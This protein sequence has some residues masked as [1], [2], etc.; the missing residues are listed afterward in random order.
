MKK[1]F[2]LIELMIVIGIIGVLAGVILSQF[3]G[4]TESSRLAVCQSNMRNLA[5]ACQSAAMSSGFYPRA[6]T[7]EYVTM[8][9]DGD[10]IRGLYSGWIGRPDDHDHRGQYS[11]HV[12][13]H[14]IGCYTTDEDAARQ[15]IS[16]GTIF[17]SMSF[18]RK[19][20]VCPGH[21]RSER[22]KS[23]RLNPQF[24]YAMNCYFGYDS[25]DGSEATAS[26]GY[27]GVAYGMSRAD[28]RLLF[29]E[30]PFTSVQDA[31]FSTSDSAELDC[32]LHYD[33]GESG[34][35]E[36]I[37]FNHVSGKLTIAHVV[38]ADC[39]TARLTLPKSADAGQLRDLTEWLCRGYDVVFVGGQYEKV[40][41]S[42]T[43]D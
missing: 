3:G 19:S 36:Q 5:Q 22:V 30:I 13:G 42:A 20:Y 1:A 12:G 40:D 41:D 7:S 8:N 14:N 24:S 27:P 31:V 28:R 43:E 34:S 25:S 15:A 9:S 35:P 37:G 16:N 33:D 38:Y 29:A 26:Y 4:A 18:D 17:A 21:A 6:G 32:V 2:T 10:M 11:G 39:H 23:A